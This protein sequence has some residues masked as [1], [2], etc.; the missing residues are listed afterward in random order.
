MDSR[1][2][3][4]NGAGLRRDAAPTFPP[5]DFGT[6]SPASLAGL[7]WLNF[8]IANVQTG[9]G[10]F[11]AVYLTVQKWT[12]VD[13][14]L[15]L[16]IGSV[17]SLAGQMPCG[18]LVDATPSKRAVA[19]LSLGAIAASALML[20]LW[21]A[22]P[23]V[24]TAEMLHG[25]AS[26]LFGPALAAITLGLVGHAVLGERLG[27]NARFAS[28]GNGIAALLMGACGQLLSARAVFYM[29]AAFTV[30]AMAALRRIR[31]VE[32]DEARSRALHRPDPA[33]SLPILAHNRR[34]FV[35]AACL[36]FFHLANTAMLP[37][38]GSVMTMRSANWAPTL[39]AACIVVP[40]LV[41]AGISPWVGRQA[42]LYGRRRL[43]LLGFGMLPVRGVLFAVITSPSVLVMVQLLDGVSAAVLGVLVPL[44]VADVTRGS[45]RFNVS[46]GI[47]GT[48]VGVGA[49]LSTMVAGLISNRF[50]SD[51]SFLTLAAIA[52][53]GLALVWL[54]MPETRPDGQAS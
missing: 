46:L 36:L 51:A 32:I 33:V 26:C 4:A 52:A 50:G 8:F 39:I 53:V 27:R 22:L 16:T 24:L 7:D 9:F 48:A 40:Q 34:L 30:P 42:E 29:A 19:A 25:V 15:A 43:L 41:V 20:A 17:V 13:I 44:V 1:P 5:E 3:A 38:L 11:I 14:G 10:P 45:G 54:C 6:P 21:P 28:V 35:F 23:L 18:A 49:S 37:F 47:V 2:P 31:P 12:Q